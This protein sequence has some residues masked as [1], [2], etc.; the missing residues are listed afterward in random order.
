MPCRGSNG[1]RRP[2]TK[3]LTV[4][5]DPEQRRILWSFDA[6]KRRA[7][8]M[9]SPRG[10]AP[11]YASKTGSIGSGSS[12]YVGIAGGCFEAFLRLASKDTS[13]RDVA[14]FAKR[15]GVLGGNSGDGSD[16]VNRYRGLA[17][18]FDEALANALRAHDEPEREPQVDYAMWAAVSANVGGLEL[19]GD[20]SARL[21][22]RIRVTTTGSLY[23]ALV[24]EFIHRL[25]ALALERVCPTPGC[26]KVHTPK[27]MP[28]PGEQSFCEECRKRGESKKSARRAYRARQAEVHRLV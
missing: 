25:D 11:R 17:R 22:V 7:P 9:L 12:R 28:P 20:W 27:R 3:P 16:P 6:P 18:K 23:G 2:K 5:L 13:A 15:W 10:T 8:K 4:K 1:S 24:V 14:S 21:G 19:H 26:G